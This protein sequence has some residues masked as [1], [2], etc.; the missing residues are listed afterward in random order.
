MKQA[1]RAMLVLRRIY[2]EYQKK[3]QRLIQIELNQF[4]PLSVNEIWEAV[5][6]L[7]GRGLFK[8]LAD[9]PVVFGTL[10]DDGIDLMEDTL[11]VSPKS[12]YVDQRNQ[13][14]VIQNVSNSN[15]SAHSSNVTQS[16]TANPDAA[17][18]LSQIEG[19]IRADNTKSDGERQEALQTIEDVK[20]QNL[21]GRVLK[22]ALNGLVSLFPAIG[23]PVKEFLSLVGK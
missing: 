20:T 1:D 4:P 5:S 2:E 6:Y 23:E 9:N 13:G 18:I 22:L 10:Q 21:T 11:P 8:Q 19:I 16:L 3:G 14:T 12:T 7:E 17:R 15:I